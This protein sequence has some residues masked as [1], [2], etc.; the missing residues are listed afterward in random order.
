MPV[1][2]I[3]TITCDCLCVADVLLTVQAEAEYAHLQLV[4]QAIERHGLPLA[5]MD[6]TASQHQRASIT[7]VM[8]AE[9]AATK[10]ALMDLCRV[11]MVS[12]HPHDSS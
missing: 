7:A 2:N 8:Q 3:D 6:P 9:Q 11:M 5:M 10:K 1:S 12:N 4:D